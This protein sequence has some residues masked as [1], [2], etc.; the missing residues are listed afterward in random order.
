MRKFY[1]ELYRNKMLIT[2]EYTRRVISDVYVAVT[3]NLYYLEHTLDQPD[4][5]KETMERIVRSGTRVRSCGISFIKDYYP[6]KGHRF[7]PFSWRNVR[8]PEVIWS[9]DMGDADLDYL[10]TEW[11]RHIIETDSAEWSEPFYD[12]Y[13]EKTALSAYMLP[14]HDQEGRVVAVL[15]ADI[16]L[17]WLTNKLN[18]TDSTI[19]KNS[20]FMASLFDMKSNSYIINYDGKYMTHSNEERIIKGNFYS[21]LAS[22][23]GSNVE[24]LVSKMKAGIKNNEKIQE[25]FLFDDEEC[26]LFY[27]PVKY[28][29]WILVTVVPCHAIDMVSYINGGVVLALLLLAIALI[30]VVFYYYMKN[31]M[32]PL[33]H[34]IHLTDN[35]AHGHYDTPMQQI[36]HNDEIGQLADSIESMQFA[37]SNYADKAKL[38][39]GTGAQPEQ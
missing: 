17:D 33:K 35:I 19:N 32:E 15:G 4:I 28:T 29:K 6:Q 7:C 14:V 31:G 25:R 13:D 23:D 8:N 20:M 26:Y 2:N 30:I 38:A 18:E 39:S 11:Y 27:I 21:Q 3:N 1:A 37:I 9:E 36:P 10:N 12:G 34:L 24:E 22:C 5:H 16:S